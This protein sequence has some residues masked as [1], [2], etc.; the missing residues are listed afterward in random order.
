MRAHSALRR[1]LAAAT[2]VPALA[3]VAGCGGSAASAA[4]TPTASPS[5]AAARTSAPAPAPARQLTA[6]QLTAAFVA[7]ADD[8]GPVYTPDDGPGIRATGVSRPDKAGCLPLVEQ[9]NSRPKHTPTRVYVS[10]TIVD[11][12][13]VGAHHDDTEFLAA[14]APGGAAATMKALHSALTSCAAFTAVDNSGDHSA[15]VI[16]RAAA[17]A[18][19]D[20]AV[21][22]RARAAGAKGDYCLVTVVR[23]GEV[24]STFITRGA[25]LNA[26]V[27][28]SDIPVAQ[29]AKLRAAHA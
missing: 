7:S 6:A 1:F 23:T 5:S 13:T 29:D 14:Y 22:F 16:A 21:A 4:R 3:V 19:G 9:M 8:P 18:I 24:T 28:P 2:V 26:P 25:G 10:Q 20:D 27:L 11:A 17:P 15:L 12:R